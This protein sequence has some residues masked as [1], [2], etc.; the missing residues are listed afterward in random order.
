MKTINHEDFI[1]DWLRNRNTT[2][3]LGLWESMYNPDFNYGEFA[4]IKS[5]AGLNSY[6]ISIKEW[7]VKTN[8]IG[9]KATTGR[10][11]GTY[12]QSDI[13]YEFAYEFSYWISVGGGK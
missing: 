10:Y 11:G 7:C 9:I 8:A 2:E 12:A 13:A 1:S 3:F 5:N 4:I 6:K